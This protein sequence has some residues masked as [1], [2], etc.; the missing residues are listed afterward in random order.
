MT[1]AL[2]FFYGGMVRRK[3]ATATIF[4]SYII[5]ALISVQ[6]VLFGY[7]LAFGPDRVGIIGGLEWA[8]LRGVGLE[9]NPDYGPTIPHQAFMAFQLMFAII[10][11]ALVTGAFAERMKFKTFMIFILL[12]TTFVYDPIAHWVWGAGGWLRNLGAIDFAGGSVVHISS[13][14]AALVA[15]LTFKDRLGFRREAMG[16]HNVPFIILGAGMLWFGWFGFNAGSALAS[17]ALAVSAFVATNTAGAMGAL[18][19][20]TLSWW[21]GGKPSAIGAV[22]GGVVGLAA[23]TPAS[24]YVEP[25]AALLIGL[26]GGLF[27]FLACQLRGK[28]GFDD[29]LDVFGCHGIGGIWGMLAAGIF[30]TTLVNPTGP[31]GLLAGN[32][33]QLLIQ[34]LAIAATSAYSFAATF[35]ILKVLDRTMGLNVPADDETGGLDLS[36]HGE[37][38]YQ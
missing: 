7:S 34:L 21:R 16:P 4:Q 29:S 9:A 26:G 20:M 38:A 11:P 32:P 17:G 30:A 3:N 15:A 37:P 23:V 24:G 1:P 27:C 28:L 13:G 2:G 35:V 25:A 36:Q 6:W 18:T 22:S 5:V 19:W 14:I 10:T 33:G 31:N 12:W 8:G